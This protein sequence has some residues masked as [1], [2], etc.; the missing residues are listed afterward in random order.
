[1]SG[2]DSAMSGGDSAMSELRY[3]CLFNNFH[4]CIKL[5]RIFAPNSIQLFTK[6]SINE[7]LF[8]S[9]EEVLQVFGHLFAPRILDVYVV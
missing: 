7:A 1:M 8:K 4:E 6:T 2:G 9:I 3:M 5:F